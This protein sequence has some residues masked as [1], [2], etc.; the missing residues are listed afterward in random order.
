MVR[1]L[2]RWLPLV[3]LGLACGPDPV[4]PVSVMALVQGPQGSY[5][6]RQVE[7]Q[8]ISDIVSVQGTVATLQGGARIIVD[9]SDPLLAGGNLNEAQLVKVFT[10]NEGLTPRANFIEKSGVLWPADFHSWNMV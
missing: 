9:G 7:L 4:A 10:K 2:S 1:P 8:T 6:T 3:M 5:E